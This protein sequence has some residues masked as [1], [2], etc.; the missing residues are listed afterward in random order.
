MN[1]KARIA[2]RTNKTTE[3]VHNITTL[4]P[5][6]KTKIKNYATVGALVSGAVVSMIVTVKTVKAAET[7]TDED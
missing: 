4:K 5:S 1:I 2:N 6:T 7:W 3:K